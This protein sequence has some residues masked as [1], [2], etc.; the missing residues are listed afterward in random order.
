MQELGAHSLSLPWALC[1][2]VYEEVMSW[3]REGGRWTRIV[4]L[5]TK[6]DMS[7]AVLAESGRLEACHKMG[8]ALN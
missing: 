1:R 6:Q 5:D 2:R 3:Q 8:Q 4:G 7:C